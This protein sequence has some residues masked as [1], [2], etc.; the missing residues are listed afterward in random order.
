MEFTDKPRKKGIPDIHSFSMSELIPTHFTS[1]NTTTSLW[2]REKVAARILDGE[3]LIVYNG[4]LLSIPPKWL[5]AH[6]GGSLA[7]LHF[8]GR[9][10]TD[11]IEANHQDDTMQLIS[12]Y[13][14]GRVELNDDG[15]WEPFLPPIA[16]GWIRRRG[17]GGNVE[18]HKEAV[19]LFQED[20]SESCRTSS[21]LLVENT[22]KEN[23]SGPTISCIEP[24]PSSLSLKQQAR[25]S[26]AY[27]EL[28]KRIADAGLYQTRYLSGYGPEIIRYTLLASCSACA[29]SR[30]W[31]ITSAVFLG[32]FWHQ[33]SFSAHDLG[34][35][36][37]THNWALDRIIATIVADFIGGLS[38]GWWV[39]V[40]LHSRFVCIPRLNFCVLQNHNVHHC[41][42]SFIL[43]FCILHRS[44]QSVVVTNH[45]SQ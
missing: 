36:G 27:R 12:K 29:Y 33:L 11:E 3:T 23:A 4:H 21:V 2:S 44:L 20:E 31:F 8:V 9:D 41:K 5:D 15:V 30:Q 26:K 32:L 7:L 37:V 13:S 19:E 42:L 28:H 17:S 35:M 10:A 16:A 38:I 24:P 43:C 39:H 14:V 40:C 34:H 22:R 18:W 1:M 45:P 6:P 25:H